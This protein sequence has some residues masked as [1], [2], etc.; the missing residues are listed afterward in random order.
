M[1]SRK[2]KKCETRFIS[3]YQNI[4]FRLFFFVTP[5]NNNGNNNSTTLRGKNDDKKKEKIYAKK[6]WNRISRHSRFDFLIFYSFSIVFIFCVYIQFLVN[7]GMEILQQPESLEHFHNRWVK[8]FEMF[9]NRK[10]GFIFVTLKYWM[11]EMNRTQCCLI[12]IF[13]INGSKETHFESVWRNES[14]GNRKCDPE[15]VTK[16]V[17]VI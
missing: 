7:K 4:R 12:Y 13:W 14:I 16:C 2:K 15:N 6:N 17:S 10:I 5:N 9:V 11:N 1:W 3:L 8:H